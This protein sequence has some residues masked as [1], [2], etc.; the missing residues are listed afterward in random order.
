LWRGLKEIKSRYN[1][2]QRKDIDL[3]LADFIWR[4]NHVKSSDPFIDALRLL[5][6]AKFIK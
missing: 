3:H 4:K 1:G 6:D 2:I 5:S